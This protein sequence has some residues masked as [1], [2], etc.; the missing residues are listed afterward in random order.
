MRCPFTGFHDC[1]NLILRD[2]DL[3]AKPGKLHHS[4]LLAIIL[5]RNAPAILEDER[6]LGEKKIGTAETK[7]KGDKSDE[8]GFGRFHD[9][10]LNIPL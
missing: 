10:G 1:L 4:A 2:G 8:L 5:D 6:V 3:A 7:E 9:S